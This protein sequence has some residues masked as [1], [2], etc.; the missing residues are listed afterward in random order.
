MIITKTE[1]FYV[2]RKKKWFK[3]GSFDKEL[4]TQ[5]V[6]RVTISVLFIPIFWYETIEGHNL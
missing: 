6:K 3:H 2:E 1:R 4:F 5:R